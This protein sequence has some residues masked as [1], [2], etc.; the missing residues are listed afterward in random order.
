MTDHS[1]AALLLKGLPVEERDRVVDRLQQAALD[2]RSAAEAG[3]PRPFPGP[4]PPRAP[5]P[6]GGAS[7]VHASEAELEQAANAPWRGSA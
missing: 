7:G 2:E 1:I 6:F 4:P 5:R 3:H